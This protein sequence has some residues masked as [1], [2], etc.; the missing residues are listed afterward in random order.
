MKVKIM[1]RFR[2]GKRI[3]LRTEGRLVAMTVYITKYAL[4][5]GILTAEAK[6]CSQTGM[7]NCVDLG[8]FH[9]YDKNWTD[10]KEKAL[11]IAKEMKQK[12][13]A[14]LQKQIRKLEKLTI[15]ETIFTCFRSC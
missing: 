1:L 11:E 10:S 13:I 5:Q 7:V 12:K 15:T 6:E 8:I 3:R 9:G 2:D 14:S 4:S